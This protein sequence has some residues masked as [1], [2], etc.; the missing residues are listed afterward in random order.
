V[1][2]LAATRLN[3]AAVTAIGGLLPAGQ[4]LVTVSTWADDLRNALKHHS[5]PLKDDPEAAAFNA[6]F[7]DNPEWHFVDLPLGATAY[8]ATSPGAGP[9]DV[10][11]AVAKCIDILESP[12]VD[13]NFSKLQALRLLVHFVGDIHQP[14]HTATGYYDVSGTQIALLK[15]PAAVDGKPNDRGGNQLCL[16]PAK[17]NGDC[18]NFDEL[19]AFWDSDMVKHVAGSQSVTK[20]AQALN[21]KLAD[22]TW[23]AAQQAQLRNPSG[24]NYHHW[25]E[26]WVKNSVT[27]ANG[28][29]DNGVTF[30]TPHFLANGNLNT[31]E[32]TLSPTYPDDQLE[33]ATVQLAAAGLHLAALLNKIQWQ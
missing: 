26:R 10:V 22:A 17:A 20:L 15:D 2:T 27:Q 1:A 29:Y 31:I 8:S 30:G 16:H 6:A 28:V 13:P 7:P 25:A 19:H 11:H 24:V 4:N 12:T 32:I 9:N 21:N 3:Q 5:G 23:K 18:A 14:L 33:R